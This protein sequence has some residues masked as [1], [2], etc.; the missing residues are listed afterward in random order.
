[1]S[2]AWGIRGILVRSPEA[3]VFWKKTH[4]IKDQIFDSYNTTTS[5]TNS[6]SLSEIDGE[7]SSPT[8]LCNPLIPGVLLTQYP[9]Y[10]RVAMSTISVNEMLHAGLKLAGYNQR[11]RNNK[12]T[13]L[14]SWFKS[15]YGSHPI[16]YCVLWH[17]LRLIDEE[18]KLQHFLM[19]LDWFKKY[20]VEAVLAGQYN[21]TEKKLFVNAAAITLRRS[22]RCLKS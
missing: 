1:M 16:V 21:L 17:K 6:S 22:S 12:Y 18:R 9:R 2:F 11:Q 5:K 15:C 3:Q 19:C 10:H 7:V 13:T 8:W 20:D 14:L 4:Q